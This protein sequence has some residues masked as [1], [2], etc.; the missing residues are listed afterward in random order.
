MG[1]RLEGEALLLLT[2]PAK[3][4]VLF[5]LFVLIQF[6]APR[7]TSPSRLWLLAA[8][9]CWHGFLYVLGLAHCCGLGVLRVFQS[10]SLASPDLSDYDLL[11]LASIECLRGAPTAQWSRS[12]TCSLQCSGRREC[13]LS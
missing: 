13:T 11:P 12:C 8:Q 1:R 4:D 10:L 2:T 3:T 5:I 9:A 7:F 6:F